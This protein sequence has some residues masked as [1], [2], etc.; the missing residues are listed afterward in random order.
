VLRFLLG[1]GRLKPELRE[2]LAAEGLVFLE[3]GLSGS[4]RYRNFRAPG[5]YFHRRITAQRFAIGLTRTRLVVYCRSGGGRIVDA[6]LSDP[7]LA[8]MDVTVEGDSLRLRIDYDRLPDQKSSG[9]ITI[10]AHTPNAAT[11]A[12]EIDTRRP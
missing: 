3:E 1:S 7:R 11:L 2:A 10:V 6:P 9:E 5:R 8:A 4:I 12:R